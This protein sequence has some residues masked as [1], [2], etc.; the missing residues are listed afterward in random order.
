MRILIS[1]L[2]EEYEYLI[3]DSPALM[4]NLMDARVLAGMDSATTATNGRNSAIWLA[5]P[6]RFLPAESETTRNRSACPL[7]T[8][9]Q[10]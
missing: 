7:T 4:P 1:E 8:F 3:V 2:L 9:R 6:S 5:R 10:F